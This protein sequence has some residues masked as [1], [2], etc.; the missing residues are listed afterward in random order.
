MS[1]PIGN[2][3]KNAQTLT[4]PACPS[5]HRDAPLIPTAQD[6]VAAGSDASCP[7][8]TGP[9]SFPGTPGLLPGSVAQRVRERSL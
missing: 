3:G 2:F 8:G 4:L 9:W 5:S 7:V 1:L 6:G